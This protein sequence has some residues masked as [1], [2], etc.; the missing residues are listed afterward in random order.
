MTCKICGIR[1]ARRFCP[2]VSGDICSQCCGSEREVTVDCPLDCEYLRQAH[3]HERI[4]GLASG[5]LPNSDIKVSEEFVVHNEHLLL[6]ICAKLFLA[7]TAGPG[8]VDS[9]VNEALESLVR[10]YRTLQSGLVY[11][12]LPANPL[13]GKIHRTVQEDIAVL[14]EEIR[15]HGDTPPRDADILGILVFLHRV[16]VSQY[17][18]RKRGRAFIDYLH[19][20]TPKPQ[21]QA[22]SSL[23]L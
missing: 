17:N 4:P 8:I 2:G 1:K 10:T 13:A 6:F 12:T 9:D 11:E 22:A 19:E 23:I 7:A 16:A 21:A 14:Q 20:F 5:E 18:G 15:K 3:Q